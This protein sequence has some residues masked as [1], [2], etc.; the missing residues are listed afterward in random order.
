MT[1]YSSIAV[2]G[3]IYRPGDP[4]VSVK[5]GKR[6]VL[7]AIYARSF[8]IRH[9]GPATQVAFGIGMEE[10]GTGFVPDDSSPTPAAR[11]RSG[12]DGGGRDTP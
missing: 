5:S 3:H 7:D 2:A 6:Y 10:L 11:G 9:R 1:E 8:T 4:L 12:A